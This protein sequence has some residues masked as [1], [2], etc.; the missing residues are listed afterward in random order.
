MSCSIRFFVSFGVFFDAVV[1]L[2]MVNQQYKQVI[3]LPRIWKLY[4]SIFEKVM[5]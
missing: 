5:F 1:Y 4:C 3:K 2:T